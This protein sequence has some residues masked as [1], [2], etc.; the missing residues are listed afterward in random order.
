MITFRFKCPACGEVLDIPVGFSGAEGCCVR[1]GS[2]I[3]PQQ[4]KRIDDTTKVFIAVAG[5]SIVLFAM[6]AYMAR[7]AGIRA[8]ERGDFAVN[9]DQL[10]SVE[11]PY[12][13]PPP[14]EPTLQFTVNHEDIAVSALRDKGFPRPRFIGFD[15]ND[16][17]AIIEIAEKDLERLGGSPRDVAQ[18]ALL[19]I[20]N[21]I[22]VLPDS[23][24][25]WGYGVMLLG[26]SPGPDLVLIRGTIAMTGSTGSLQWVSAGDTVAAKELLTVF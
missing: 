7:Q 12:I 13:P 26:E 25:E 2:L 23:D 5:I 10:R 3:R 24:P 15:G 19:A 8:L 16:V 9:P 14:P 18:A 17:N 1:C 22:Y 20:R 4:P 21:A 11:V 6:V